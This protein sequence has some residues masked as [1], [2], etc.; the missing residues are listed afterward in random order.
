MLLVVLYEVNDGLTFVTFD[1]LPVFE[2][3]RLLGLILRAPLFSRVEN[4]V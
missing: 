2:P 1:G 3:V 4:W